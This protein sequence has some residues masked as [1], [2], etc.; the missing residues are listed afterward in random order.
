MVHFAFN[1]CQ[2]VEDSQGIDES[3]LQAI[4]RT[5]EDMSVGM[6]LKVRDSL[7]ELADR[8]ELRATNRIKD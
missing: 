7:R 2:T 5:T 6:L 3:L 4:D 8:V 1:F